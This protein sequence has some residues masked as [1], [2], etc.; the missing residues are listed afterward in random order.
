[1]QQ[2]Y[3]VD[4]RSLL[5]DRYP[6]SEDWIVMQSTAARPARLRVGIVGAGRVGAVLG[7][8]LTRAGHQVV[9]ASGVSA[10][11]RRRAA[12]LLPGVPLVPADEVARSADL[13]LLA[14][15]DDILA[16]LVAGL[17]GTGAIRPG[18]L[19]A[20]TSGSHGLAVLAPATAAG[21]IP[22]ALHPAMTFADRPEDLDRLTGVPFG[23]TAPDELWPVAEA[24]VVEMGGEPHRVPEQ[25][26]PLYHA[27]LVV[28]A[29]HLVTL[30]NEATDLLRAAGVDSPAT[31]LAPLLSAALDNAL[32]AG[33]A[34]ATGPVVRGDAGT[35]ATHLAVLTERAPDSVAAYLAM[36]RR[37]ADRAI[38]AG[39]LRPA[40][41]AE[42]L[43]VLAVAE[44]AGT[45]AQA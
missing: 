10:A 5:H 7:A 11:T 8:A 16:G 38:G 17:V 31:V 4:S 45:R 2:R 26:R 37:T 1:M 30:V 39:R 19:V 9:A 41:A 12:R 23:A 44:Q 43:E 27:A 33:D 20:H 22:L 3:R 34:A 21:A 36:A 29:N 25:A 40:D 6:E 18:T 14:V 42:L 28:G 35:V 24:L 15:P 13:L 32:R